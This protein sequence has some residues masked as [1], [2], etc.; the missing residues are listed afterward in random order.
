MLG[1]IFLKMRLFLQNWDFSKKIGH[2]EKKYEFWRKGQ[3]FKKIFSQF[4]V[5]GT[6][7]SFSDVFVPL[8]MV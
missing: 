1:D 4:I 7:H 8:V 5:H 6:V 2:F 3:I